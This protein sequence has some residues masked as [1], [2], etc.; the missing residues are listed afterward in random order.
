MFNKVQFITTLTNIVAVAIE[1]KRLFRKQIEQERLRREMELA[2]EMQHMLIPNNLP[3]KDCYELASIYK[4]QLGVGGDYFD[5]VELDDSKFAFCIGDISGKGMAAALLMAN[6][7][8]LFH[9]MINKR[10]PLDE[11][12]KELNAA[13]FNITQGERFITF[14]VAE[15]DIVERTLHYVNAGHNPPFMVRDGELHLLKRGCTILGSFPELPEVQI[16]KI[17]IASEALLLTYT[18]GLTDI[19][20]EQDEFMNQEK[21]Q[22]FVQANYRLSAS[23][24]NKALWEYTEAFIGAQKYPDDFTILTCKLFTPPNPCKVGH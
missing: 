11:F 6:F 14:F 13:L 12:I 16:G 15:Y 7:Q 2:G 4:P 10:R 21:L 18:D 9:T 8:S 23:D 1:N 20:D 24:F 19:Q 3:K 17:K 22:E 5:Y